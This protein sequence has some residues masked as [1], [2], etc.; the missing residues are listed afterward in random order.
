MS[1]LHGRDLLSSKF[2]TAIITDA[3]NRAFFVP[4]KYTIGDYF[5]ADIEKQV[6]VFK[7]EGKDIHTYRDTLVKSFRVIFYNTTHYRPVSDKSKMLELALVKNNLPKAD[8]MLFSVF[9]IL[10]KREKDPFEKTK[11][12]DLKEWIAKRTDEVTAKGKDEDQVSDFVKQA[13]SIVNYLES[14]KIDEICT[15]LKKISEFIEDDLIS[16]DP[17]F[18]GTVISGVMEAD[19]ENRKVTNAPIKSK[20]AWMKIV[21]VVLFI[22][23]VGAIVYIAY[24]NG[25]FDSLAGLGAI[26]DI[27]FNIGGGVTASGSDIVAK[28]PTPEAMKCAIERGDLKLASVPAEFKSLVNSAEC[29]PTYGGEATIP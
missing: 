18:F 21:M 3:S 28:Y 6:Y 14:L 11:I 7:I 13:Q 22:G 8:M 9:K 1:I 25:A 29:T 16:P 24:E 5:I 26:G 19:M 10:G 2:I 23:L 15:P 17:K 20:T 4:I 27:D 12:S